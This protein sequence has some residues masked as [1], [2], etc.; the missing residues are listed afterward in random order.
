MR[1]RLLGAGA[2]ALLA[3][4]A[5]CRTTPPPSFLV[6]PPWE[7]RRPQLQAREHFDLKGRVAV[8]AGREGFN[9]SLRWSQQGERSQL[10]FEGPLGAGAVQVSASGKELDVVTARGEHLDSAAAHAELAARLGFDPPL[11]SLRYW[12]LGVPDPSHPATEE[13]DKEQQHLEH[14]TQAGWHIDYGLYIAVEG[15]SLP[16]RLTLTRDAVRVR[17]LVEDWDL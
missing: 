9:A 14:L 7:V 10:T 1:S 6:L 8:A 15:E 12:V 13:L 11:P 16:A 3:T 2:A 17:L 4:L 5:A